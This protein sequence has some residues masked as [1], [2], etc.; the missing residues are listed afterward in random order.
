VGEEH[1]QQQWYWMFI[2]GNTYFIQQ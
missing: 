1:P 2:Q